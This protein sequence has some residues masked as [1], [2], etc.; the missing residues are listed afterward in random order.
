MSSVNKVILVGRAGKD[1]ETKYM[2]NGEAV[3]SLSIATSENW[4]DKAGD[5]KEKTE[6]HNCVAYRKLAEII[7]EYVKSGSMLYVEG[8]L[9]TEKWEKDGVTRYTTKIVVNEMKMLGGKPQGETSEAPPAGKP[10]I[11]PKNSFDNFDDDIPFAHH[12]K[13]G[14]GVS[15]RCM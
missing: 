1:P 15:W 5:K 8:K 14:A 2:P 12:G 11:D 10:V 13:A 9:T 7:G 4:K 6:W 3:T